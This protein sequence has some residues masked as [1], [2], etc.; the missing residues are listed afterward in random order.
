MIT[1]AKSSDTEREVLFGNAADR[2]GI[3]SRILNGYEDP[4]SVFKSYYSDFS[5]DADFSDEGGLKEIETEQEDDEGD[6]WDE[7]GYDDLVE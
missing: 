1:I 7:S 4:E 6:S 5:D 3:L 2:A